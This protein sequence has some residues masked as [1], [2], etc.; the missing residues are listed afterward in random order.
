MISQ[1]HDRQSVKQIG[2]TKRHTLALCL[3]KISYIS[4]GQ[5][6]ALTAFFSVPLLILVSRDAA[7]PESEGSF[8]ARALIRRRD[9]SSVM[10]IFPCASM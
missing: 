4:D 2:Y 10:T 8:E 1:T 3:L 5:K 7:L 9:L 6:D